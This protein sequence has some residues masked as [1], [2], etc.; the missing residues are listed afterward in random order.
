MK[1]AVECT[2]QQSRT[3][4]IV[5]GDGQTVKSSIFTAELYQYNFNGGFEIK[6]NL[7]IK[8]LFQIRLSIYIA[9]A[10][11]KKTKK[12]SIFYLKKLILFILHNHFLKNS[13]QTIYFILHFI[14]ILF[15]YIF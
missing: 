11:K 5:V 12:L 14:K 15:I 2:R 8:S 9:C 1:L 7:F 6:I 13:C 10:Q 4:K 3:F